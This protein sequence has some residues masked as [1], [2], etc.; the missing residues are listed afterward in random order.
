[1][2]RWHCVELKSLDL[3]KENIK[4]LGVHISYNKN[5]Q[6]DINFCTAVKNI[7]NEIELWHMRHLSL[8]A[9]IN[10]FKSL[11]CLNSALGLTYY[12]P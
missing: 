10:T 7:C 9:K 12:C 5:L 2:Q 4:I 6:D 3:T 1:M 11:V 8:E